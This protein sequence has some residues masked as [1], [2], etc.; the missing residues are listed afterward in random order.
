M[1]VHHH[2]RHGKKKWTEYFWEFL[3]LFLAVFAGFLAENQREHF[4]EHQREKQFIISLIRDVETDTARIN[5]LIKGRDLRH[6]RLDSLLFLLNSDSATYFTRDI[7]FLAVTIPR[8]NLFQLTPSDGTMQQLKN[9]GSLRLIKS[10]VTLDSLLKY[11]A[12]V[13][14]LV[15]LDEQEQSIVNIQREMAPKI[16]NGIELSKFS[17]VENLAIRVNLDPPL[18]PNYK[19]SLN[20][21]N[22][23]IVSVINVNKGYKR[24]VRKIFTQAVNLLNVLKKEYHLK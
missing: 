10:R 24:E 16:F 19:N 5:E 15:R 4:V 17:D 12:A 14:S 9:S 11:D 23:R 13:R 8:I 6:Q 7:Y 1:E 20:E 22:Y 21:F 18:E 3:M 2:S